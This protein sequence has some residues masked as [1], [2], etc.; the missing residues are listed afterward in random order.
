MR[1]MTALGR[2]TL[3]LQKTWAACGAGLT[4]PAA[5]LFIRRES[6]RRAYPYTN[7]YDLRIAVACH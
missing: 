7:Y 6:P 3:Y 1:A 4:G 2:S 5:A